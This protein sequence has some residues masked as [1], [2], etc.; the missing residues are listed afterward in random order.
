MVGGIREV[1]AGYS[2]GTRGPFRRH[3]Q[4][5]LDEIGA[6]LP[7]APISPCT[8]VGPARTVRRAVHLQV[9]AGSAPSALCVRVPTCAR[10]MGG[11]G[12][13]AGHRPQVC[14][15]CRNTQYIAAMRHAVQARARR[16][17]P[18]PSAR[19]SGA[20]NQPARLGTRRWTYKSPARARAGVRP[21]RLRPSSF[22]A[23]E[24]LARSLRA[25][26]R[27]RAVG[28]SDRLMPP[29][30]LAANAGRSEAKCRRERRIV[31]P[32]LR[33]H[34]CIFACAEAKLRPARSVPSRW[35]QR[36]RRT[37]EGR[38]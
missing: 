21:Q 12:A 16:A 20:P 13:G 36:V 18:P 14:G 24:T 2:R 38:S 22:H 27:A 25:R 19:G 15:S 34:G 29:A 28:R 3:V 10:A 5:A 26:S 1:L 9:R 23:P 7:T 6:R 31:P 33:T 8:P 30:L 17:C 32:L 35:L 4:V 11:A 37:A